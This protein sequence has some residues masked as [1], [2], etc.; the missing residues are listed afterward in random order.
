MNRTPPRMILCLCLSLLMALAGV[1]GALACNGRMPVMALVI[2]GH[3]GAE[4]IWLD[5]EGRPVPKAVAHCPDCLG[6]PA[7]TLSDPPA[8][9]ALAA[10]GFA[11][12]S[13]AAVPPLPL[14]DPSQPFQ[15]RGPPRAA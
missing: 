7:V 10:T 1:Q 11:W 8:L 14:S 3:A 5:A 6:T 15:A 12:L 4:T 2:C 13:P 9:P